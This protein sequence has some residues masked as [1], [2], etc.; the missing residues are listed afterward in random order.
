MKFFFIP[1]SAILIA[2]MRLI[3]IIEGNLMIREIYDEDFLSDARD[4]AF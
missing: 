3:P 2:E 1:V 4:L